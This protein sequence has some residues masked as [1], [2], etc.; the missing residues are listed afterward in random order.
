MEMWVQKENI[1]LGVA[2]YTCDL[3]TLEAEVERSKF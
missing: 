3:S 1:L 2:A